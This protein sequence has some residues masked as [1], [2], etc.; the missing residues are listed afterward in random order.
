MKENKFERKEMLKTQDLKEMLGIGNTTVYRLMHSKGFPSI[1]I[2]R[3]YFV[4]KEDFLKWA[5][6]Y[7]YDSFQL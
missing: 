6:E 3:R 7:E 4:L 5:R 1:K 2:G